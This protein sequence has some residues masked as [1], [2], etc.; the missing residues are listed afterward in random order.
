MVQRT[1]NSERLKQFDAL[2]TWRH[3][4]DVIVQLHQKGE[5]VWQAYARA[6]HTGG[7]SA[8]RNSVLSELWETGR[9]LLRSGDTREL[10][11]LNANGVAQICAFE[12]EAA[13]YVA[14]RVLL[15]EPSNPEPRVP[16][17]K[18]W[19]AL[20]TNAYKTGN[21]R[22]PWSIDYTSPAR[23]AENTGIPLSTI[24]RIATNP[25]ATVGAQTAMTLLMEL[26]AEKARD[27]EEE[28]LI[29][30]LDARDKLER[31]GLRY[32]YHEG[33]AAFAQQARWVMRLT[34][35]ERQALDDIVWISVAAQR[36]SFLGTT[37]SQRLTDTEGAFLAHHQ[38]EPVPLSRRLRMQARRF[39]DHQAHLETKR[40]DALRR[41]LHHDGTAITASTV[42]MRTH[43]LRKSGR[44]PHKSRPKSY[45]PPVP[46]S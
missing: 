34:L 43:R 17:V 14:D 40:A 35:D 25:T 16:A 19:P 26:D 37:P 23:L 12:L 6:R 18:L 31:Q 21:N 29:P 1:A 3:V 20:Q 33:L 24:K 41:G 9:V 5:N 22:A 7:V 28:L 38:R 13:D 2:V 8:D 4:D 32:E 39:F 27:L 45:R 10:P 44:L 15:E 30:W 36:E 46:A 42:T 11:R